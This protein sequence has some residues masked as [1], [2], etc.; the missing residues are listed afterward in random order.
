MH[1]TIF[2]TAPQHTELDQGAYEDMREDGLNHARSFDVLASINLM[3][4]DISRFGFVLDE[5]RQRVYDEELTFIAEGIDRPLYSKFT[6]QNIEG[7]L[8]YFDRGEWR[9]YK[10][11]LIRAEKIAR[12]EASEDPRKQFLHDWTINDELICYKLE[13]LGSGEVLH[14][15]NPFP[16]EMHK[17]FGSKFLKE[18]CGLQPERQMGFMYRAERHTD[19]SLTIETHS[20][21]RSDPEAFE[22][23]RR[24]VAAN[25]DVGIKDAVGEYD[26]SL[27][28]Q[29]GIKHNAGRLDK[30]EVEACSFLAQNAAVI[31]RY[32]DNIERLASSPI[33]EEA[34]EKEKKRLTYGTWALIK[35]L[36]D[37]SAL[38][39][40]ARDEDINYLPPDM[41]DHRTQQA[42]WAA[43]ARGEIMAGCGGSISGEILLA[44][45]A[46]EVFG[47]IFNPGSSDA[48]KVPSDEKGSLFFRCGNGH[49]NRRPRGDVIDVCTSCSVSVSC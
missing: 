40:F 31:E 35:E 6:L 4:H 9:P 18:E 32:L 10:S 8:Q 46:E 36:L 43:T 7:S 27:Y 13:G 34:L 11:S 42:Y 26:S 15:D 3:R 20:V 29:T 44:M 23:A 45:S 22:R 33:G 12:R 2:E 37:E 48:E 17:R 30:E 28:E 39:L 49:L 14:W 41:I 1:E 21:D 16:H 38:P 25:P 24:A 47:L 19:G 5:T